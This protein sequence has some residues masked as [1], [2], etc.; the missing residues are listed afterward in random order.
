MDKKQTKLLFEGWRKFLNEQE[1]KPDATTAGEIEKLIKL[2]YTDFVSKLSSVAADPK[3]QAVLKYGLKDGKPDD[4]KVQI[5][6]IDV[7]VTKLKPTQNEI[8]MDKSLAFALSDLNT[9]KKYQAGGSVL[10]KT[11]IVVA[12]NGTLIIDGHHRWS[13]VYCVNPKASIQ[14][15]NLNVQGL[16]P[17]DYLKIVQMSIAADIKQIK[18]NTV[19]GINLLTCNEQQLKQYINSNAQGKFKQVVDANGGVDKLHAFIWGNILQMRKTSQPVA[20]APKR[21]FM[22]QTDDSPNWSKQLGS[23]EVNFR[24]PSVGL[25]EGKRSK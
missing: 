15:V 25:S 19:E 8:D 4:E 23:G 24:E 22:P 11:R 3:V 13:Q 18:I 9:F 5:T 17:M 1:G 16:K 10:V 20:G 7:P 2:P 12:N 21:D 6:Q 14:S